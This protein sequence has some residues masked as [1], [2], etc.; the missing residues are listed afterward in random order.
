MPITPLEDTSVLVTGSWRTTGAQNLDATF[1][2]HTV[3]DKAAALALPAP[4]RAQIRG[5]AGGIGMAS[6]QSVIA[7]F[8][9]LEII[10]NFGVGYDGVDTTAAAAQGVVVTNTPGVLTEE[11]A[12]TALGLLLMTVRELSA[13][14]RHQANQSR[15]LSARRAPSRVMPLRPRRS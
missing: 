11:V 12:D 5:I 10:A 6:D 13:A 14:E 7:A 4:V 8:P 2:T 15:R 3:L 1:S 9:N